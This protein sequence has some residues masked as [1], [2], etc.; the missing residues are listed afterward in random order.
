MGITHRDIKPQNILVVE[1]DPLRVKIADFGIS[2]R[3]STHQTDLKTRV[4]TDGYSAPEILSLFDADKRDS[5]YTSAVDIWSL[6]CVL[7]YT[8]TKDKPFPSIQSLEKYLKSSAFP[9]GPLI[10][11][12]V[13]ASGRQFIK[14]L[15]APLPENRRKATL[16]I[17][18]D[19]AINDAEEPADS[20]EDPARNAEGELIFGLLGGSTIDSASTSHYTPPIQHQEEMELH[21]FE[22]WHVLK[23]AHGPS[24][25]LRPLL[26]AGAK[27]DKLLNGYTALHLAAKQGPADRLQMLLR[28]GS[29]LAVRT[30]PHRE[31]VLHLIT[32]EGD[33]ELFE[34]KYNLIRGAEELEINA[35]DADGNT[36]LHMA[37][38]RFGTATA[39][40]LLLE[41][42]AL[43]ESK[44]KYG[45][46]PLLYALSLDQWE[47]AMLLLEFRADPDAQDRLGRAA[48]HYAI[49]SRRCSLQLLERLIQSGAAL[50]T[51]DNDGL[52]PLA[53]A[54]KLN[55][56]DV[57][58]LL[59]DH[60]ASCELGVPAL[61]KQVK[62][63]QALRGIPWPIGAG[64]NWLEC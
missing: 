29:D 52:S 5:L 19:W 12:G 54:T 20:A 23:S 44:G 45:L 9:E 55:K 34:A 28:Y 26:D 15:L 59:I 62:R 7:Y 64:R 8:L 2:K 39:V 61:E 40:Q 6:G 42:G 60:G 27:S 31:T 35:E 51:K 63:A 47:K 16:D 37:V 36:A 30:Q 33:F 22:L 32:Y 17:L 58:Y 53:L 10:E 18:S 48:L 11:R 50:D 49:A 4:G 41:A 14:S 43:T 38:A 3:I 21:S 56:K 57:M 46:T 25:R 13:G 1:K 24:D